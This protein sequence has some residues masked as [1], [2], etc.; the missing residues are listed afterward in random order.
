[1]FTAGV[2]STASGVL[3]TGASGDP[4]AEPQAAAKEDRYL[5]ALD[6]ATGAELWRIALP[7]AI[8]GSPMT[9]LVEGTQYVAVPAGDTLF[10]FSLRR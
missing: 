2:L 7:G 6:A 10:T 9:Y 3:F 1:M 5:Y 8:K 4:A